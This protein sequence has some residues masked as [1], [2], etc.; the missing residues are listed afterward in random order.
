MS[1]SKFVIV[2][3]KGFD[4]DLFFPDLCSNA[5]FNA[6]D[7]GD[8]VVGGDWIVT[9]LRD[10]VAACLKTEAISYILL[11]TTNKSIIILSL[12]YKSY[13]MKI[14]LLCL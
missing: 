9:G 4:P 7:T 1:F 14:S 10:C 11:L 6:L 2:L 13:E 12:D 8:A 3:E 5:C